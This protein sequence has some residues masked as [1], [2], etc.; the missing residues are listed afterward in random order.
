M[1]WKRDVWA[2]LVLPPPNSRRV[3]TP[4]C[5]IASNFTLNASIACST[6]DLGVAKRLLDKLRS[7][8]PPILLCG[9]RVTSRLASLPNSRRNSAVHAES[10][11]EQLAVAPHHHE[12]TYLAAFGQPLVFG[13]L[14]KL[15]LFLGIDFRGHNCWS[16]IRQAGTCS[17]ASIGIS[18]KTMKEK[19]SFELLQYTTLGRTL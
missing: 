19:C 13:K 10:A 7:A 8:P 12:T 14:A 18:A 9:P 11:C 1:Q 16:P 15:L 3:A 6:A 17:R 2:V 5:S 4:F